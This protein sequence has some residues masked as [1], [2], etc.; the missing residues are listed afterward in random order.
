MRSSNRIQHLSVGKSI[1]FREAEERRQVTRAYIEHVYRTLA[2]A[3][4]RVAEKQ[5]AARV[6]APDIDLAIISTVK[7]K[8]E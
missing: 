4:C 7:K 5:V 2:S 1:L 3:R 8:G 6:L